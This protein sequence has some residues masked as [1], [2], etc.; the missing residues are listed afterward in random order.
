MKENLNN[1]PAESV[2][3]TKCTAGD[4]EFSVTVEADEEE[5]EEEDVDDTDTTVT[6]RV[7]C[8]KIHSAWL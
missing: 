6:C 1:K 3:V 5:E 8:C 2:L 7:L 4:C